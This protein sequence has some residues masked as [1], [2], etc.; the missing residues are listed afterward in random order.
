MNRMDPREESSAISRALDGVR[1]I[2]PKRVDSWLLY[3]VLAAVIAVLGM[4]AWLV[5][6]V[7]V[8]PTQP[9]T[10][11]ERNVLQLEQIVKKQPHNGK[12][13]GDW[14][15]ALIDAGQY[16]KAGRVIDDGLE[17]AEET[18]P[19]LLRQAQLAHLQGRD[20]EALDVAAQAI[21]SAR[22]FRDKAMEETRRKGVTAPPASSPEIVDA[23]FLRGDILMSLERY[24]DAV[25]AFTGALDEQPR[26][27]DVLALR[28][29]AYAKLGDKDRA[30]A[31]FKDALRFDPENAAAI[32]GLEALGVTDE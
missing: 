17:S 5:Y 12:A 18:A 27:S 4:V 9:R 30:T 31:D 3:A 29:S 25:E 8:P 26:L 16:F 24:E 21:E 6:A 1:D 13:W 23:Q 14:A 11:V 2:S 7:V 28:G 15:A 19:L 10:A 32:K 20:E 22:A